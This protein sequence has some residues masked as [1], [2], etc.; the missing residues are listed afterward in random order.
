MQETPF[1]IKG[2]FLEDSV[3][4]GQP[5]HYSLYVSH[6]KAQEVFFPNANQNFGAFETVKREFFATKTT[7]SGS[8]DSAVYTLR[9]FNLAP[10]Q[11]LQIPIYLLQE[12]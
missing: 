12:P 5:V 10:V 7:A 2:K 9:L 6:P 3:V 8:L 1:R 4:I 11:K